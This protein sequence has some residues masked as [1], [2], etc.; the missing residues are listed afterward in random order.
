V[1]KWLTP[2][3]SG[4]LAD[5]T[6]AYT[7]AADEFTLA[8][9]SNITGGGVN[10]WGGCNVN[11]A[12]VL[13]GSATC[14]TGNFSLW[15]YSDSGSNSP[16]TLLYIFGVGNAHQTATGKT[17]AARGQAEYSYSGAIPSGV[18]LTA[19]TEYWLGISD[20]TPS[21]FVWGWETTAEGNGDAYQYCAG[22]CSGLTLLAGTHERMNSPL[23]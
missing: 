23:I 9:G 8:P 15:L 20:N 18:V 16:G 5:Q 14:P 6:Y 13:S 19:G 2:Y 1:S 12:G 4:N 11:N 10:W 21:N 17:I 7:Q 3:D 22:P